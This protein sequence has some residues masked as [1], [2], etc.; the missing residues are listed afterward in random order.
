MNAYLL[1]RQS[2]PP[3]HAF[4]AAMDRR[5]VPELVTWLTGS[6]EPNLCL[7]DDEEFERAKSYEGAIVLSSKFQNGKEIA[8][9]FGPRENWLTEFG[10]FR[11]YFAE[12]ERRQAEREHITEEIW[13]GCDSRPADLAN[14]ALP[15]LSTRKTRLFTIACC[16]LVSDKMVDPRSRSA[17]QVALSYANGTATDQEL[18]VAFE[19][20]YQAILSITASGRRD[21]GVDVQGG[22]E[23]AAAVLAS[24]AADSY[25]RTPGWQTPDI[26]HAGTSSRRP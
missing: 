21:R 14:F 23:H 11:D 15:R 13:L 1:I 17:M 5:E 19:A 18:N 16:E 20:E 22:P 9:V 6:S 26:R 3:A 4:L 8:I 10:Q 7:A 2:V 12:A 25:A 24:F